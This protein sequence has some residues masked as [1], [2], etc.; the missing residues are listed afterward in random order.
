MLHM[1][2]QFEIYFN[3]L[4]NGYTFVGLHLVVLWYSQGP[5]FHMCVRR[6]LTEST[7]L[8]DKRNRRPQSA[9]VNYCFWC[10]YSVCWCLIQCSFSDC[11][12]FTLFI[13]SGNF[14]MP[15]CLMLKSLVVLCSRKRR[16][17]VQCT[18][19]EIKK[20]IQFCYTWH[21]LVFYVLS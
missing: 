6:I 18:V 13:C 11:I 5:C 16:E 9:K 17:S 1:Q 8:A 14:Y 3:R 7:V 20:V 2:Y 19:Y 15:I 10:I 12:P 4:L 21:F